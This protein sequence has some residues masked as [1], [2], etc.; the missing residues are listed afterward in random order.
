MGCD[1]F[2]ILG[3]VVLSKLYELW[4]FILLLIYNNIFNSIFFFWSWLAR[5]NAPAW[6]W[7]L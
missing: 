7:K 3:I 5:T 2:Q 1:Y 4:F 6:N